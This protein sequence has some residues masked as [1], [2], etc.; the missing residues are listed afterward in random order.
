MK[1]E[2]GPLTHLKPTNPLIFL[3]HLND[4]SGIRLQ[5][6]FWLCLH[7]QQRGARL[8]ARHPH[9][10]LVLLP[11]SIQSIREEQ[12]RAFGYWTKLVHGVSTADVSGA[13]TPLWQCWLC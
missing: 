6:S 11:Y 9:Q 12:P 7:E 1:L 4:N 8:G 3:L 10:P 5:D 13:K 2:P